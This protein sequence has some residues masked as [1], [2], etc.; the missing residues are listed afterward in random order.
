MTRLIY[1]LVRKETMDSKIQGI[2]IT[3]LL[4]KGL[5]GLSVYIILSIFSDSLYYILKHQSFFKKM[6]TF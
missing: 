4:A 6:D 2:Y 1:L 5:K 3:D